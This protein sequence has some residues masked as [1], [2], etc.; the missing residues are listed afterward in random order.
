MILIP[1]LA[2]QDRDPNFIKHVTIY[3]N[4]IGRGGWDILQRV[5]SLVMGDVARTGRT[6]PG[7]GFTAKDKCNLSNDDKCTIGQEMN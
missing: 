3:Y 5:S 7:N 4:I 1:G 6:L 2:S